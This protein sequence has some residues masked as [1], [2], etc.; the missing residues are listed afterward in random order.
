MVIIAIKN[1]TKSSLLGLYP[2]D[3]V[4]FG[5]MVSKRQSRLVAKRQPEGPPGDWVGQI[6]REE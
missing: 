3:I 1:V 5:K 2:E 4:H 6:T